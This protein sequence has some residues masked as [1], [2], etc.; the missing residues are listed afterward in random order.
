M[1]NA[2]PDSSGR[3]TLKP[4]G[5]EL[6]GSAVG[7]KGGQ[8][9]CSSEGSP[10]RLSSRQARG[11]EPAADLSA[12]RRRGEPS[13]RQGGGSGAAAWPDCDPRAAPHWQASPLPG[14]GAHQPPVNGNG[15]LALKDTSAPGGARGSRARSTGPGRNSFLS[16][17]LGTSP[18]VNAFSV[19]VQVR[20]MTGGCE[21]QFLGDLTKLLVDHGISLQVKDDKENS[22]HLLL[23]FCPIATY[24]TAD[25]SNAL[26]ELGGV[27]NV[28]VVALHHKPKENTNFVVDKN[29]Q[30][31]HPALVA[32]VHARYSMQDG[33]YLC[34]ANEEAVASV[35]AAIGQ[36]KCMEN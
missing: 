26:E 17:L 36:F 6:R 10:W 31:H 20:G 21:K 34:Q 16:R 9:G 30:V 7:Q 13:G 1:E 8:P 23:L 5:P 18:P 12:G 29:V 3:S 35:A 24:V 2:L 27:R 4:A 32:T 28:L 22:E 25:I 15:E 11:L 19:Q 33:F 14:S